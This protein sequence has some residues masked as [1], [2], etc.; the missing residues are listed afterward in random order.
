MTL[1]IPEDMKRTDDALLLNC[2]D[3]LIHKTNTIHSNIGSANYI[4]RDGYELPIAEEL[5]SPFMYEL[6]DRVG[7]KLVNGYWMPKR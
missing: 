3:Q 5:L 7:Y 1:K 6:A 2:F 4:L